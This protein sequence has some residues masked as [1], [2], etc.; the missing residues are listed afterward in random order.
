[1]KKP[2]FVIFFC[3]VFL[4]SVIGFILIKIEQAHLENY[5]YFYDAVSYS[6][7]NARLHV[8][9]ANEGRFT[10][11]MQEWLGNKRHPLRTVP[12]LLFAPSLLASNVGHMATVLPMLFIFLGLLGWTVYRRTGCTPYALTCMAL[13][14]AIPGIF[15]PGLG[16]G[17]YWLDLP[18]AFLVGGAALCL[19]NSSEGRSL[20]WLVGFAVLASCAVLSRYIAAA[21]AFVICVP[22]LGG[23]LIQRW[24]REG[25]P[26]K[27]ILLPLSV[28]SVTTGVLAGYFLIFHLKSNLQ[29]YTVYG[30]ALNQ[31]LLGSITFV[32]HFLVG[33]FFGIPGIFILSA[34][35]LVNLVLFWK[36]VSQNWKDLIISVWYASAVILFLVLVLR[37]GEGGHATMYAVPLVFFAVV[38]PVTISQNWSSHKVLVRLSAIL[39]AVALLLGG[40]AALDNY[41][42]ATHPSPEAKEQK[43][44]DVALAQELIRAGGSVVFCSYFDEYTVIPVMETFYRYGKLPLAAKKL[45]TVHESYWS[46][47]YPNLSANAL[48]EIVYANTT[49]EVDIAVVFNDPVRAD[50]NTKWQGKPSPKTRLVAKYVAEQ[51]RNDPNWKRVFVLENSHYGTLAGYRNLTR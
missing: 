34:I 4:T 19:L 13:F 1:M 18:A 37:A 41:S 36:D 50:T 40:R 24:W 2:V 31:S 25:A 30:Y 28:I 47:F 51:I 26:V 48:T 35:C 46:G 39:I 20:K 12:L 3:A 8:R 7:D 49:K 38:S 14:C 22:V 10:L 27:T 43:A 44:L 11:A 17:A 23:Y 21:Y 6:L 9:L 45:F 5:S 16:L 42:L 33:Y 32:I 15:H 29:Y